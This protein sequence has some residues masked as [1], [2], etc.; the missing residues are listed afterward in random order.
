M[1]AHLDHYVRVW[2]L[3]HTAESTAKPASNQ[4]VD[5]TPDG[6]WAVSTDEQGEVV[7]VWE[8]DTARPVTDQ[9][10]WEAAMRTMRAV[11]EVRDEQEKQALAVVNQDEEGTTGSS[12]SPRNVGGRRKV[13]VN[14]AHTVVGDTNGSLA[15]TYEER[16]IKTSEAE[17]PEQPDRRYLHFDLTIW[18]VTVTE[19]RPKALVGHSSPIHAVSMTP[20][21][22]RAVSA[23]VGRTVRVWDLE[24][25]RE[26]QTLRGHRGMV[27]DTQITPDGHLAVSASEDRTVCVWDLR[28][29]RCIA[30]YTGDQPMR[31]C[32]VSGEGQAVVAS[33]ALGR[34]HL[35][36]L[37]G[38]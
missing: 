31:H 38:A 33:D 12:R 22:R 19:P 1:V 11:W 13:A 10:K 16:I 23:C 30:V 21:G 6:Q 5:I 24:V 28:T 7:G 9:A 14:F 37:E 3:E 25:G 36:R 26:L 34:A 35:L 8:L 17:E 29:W 20:D 27:R 15:L 18:D 4:F 32:A 2:A